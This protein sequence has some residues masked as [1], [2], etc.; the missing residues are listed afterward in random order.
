MCTPTVNRLNRISIYGA[1]YKFIYVLALYLKAPARPLQHRKNYIQI[2]PYFALTFCHTY[3]PLA[4]VDILCL[5]VTSQ[6]SR[7][8]LLLI[9][10]QKVFISLGQ[11]KKK[12]R[13]SDRWHLVSVSIQTRVYSVAVK[14]ADLHTSF[15]ASG[16]ARL[17]CKSA[18]G[19]T[20]A[21]LDTDA[22]R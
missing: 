3:S 19:S 2:I 4:L 1:P 21:D 9:L 15:C 17:R 12:P 11:K 20:D 18:F 7:Q 13:G 16:S 22:Q 8:G 6:L 14:F 5:P 10:T